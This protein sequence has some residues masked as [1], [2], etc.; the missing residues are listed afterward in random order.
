[1][2]KKEKAEDELS[3][4][5]KFKKGF[6][7]GLIG[8]IVATIITIFI[9]TK[10]SV[11]AFLEL[12]FKTRDRVEIIEHKQ[13]SMDKVSTKKLDISEFNGHK[14]LNDEQFKSIESKLEIMLT[15]MYDMKRTKITYNQVSDTTNN[16]NIVDI[17]IKNESI[18]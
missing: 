2:G 7:N 6:I 3:F 16:K 5:E 4:L 9:F 14:D 13:D 12:P 18:N 10:T 8:A 1:M 15:L 11:V 17:N